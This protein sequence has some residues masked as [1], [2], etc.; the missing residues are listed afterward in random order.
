MRSFQHPISQMSRVRI[1][2]LHFLTRHHRCPVLRNLILA[3]VMWGI[4]WLRVLYFHHLIYFYMGS[5]CYVL[6][7]EACNKDYYHYYYIN[8]R[9]FYFQS[10]LRH[11]DV[12]FCTYPLTIC[13]ARLFT[14]AYS[15]SE[16]DLMKISLMRKTGIRN[17]NITEIAHHRNSSMNSH[18]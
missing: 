1:S 8:C 11:H 18:P 13:A 12:Y 7:L 5:I 16:I 17:T 4:P 9:P 6:L 14:E 2:N 10:L 15:C 3:T